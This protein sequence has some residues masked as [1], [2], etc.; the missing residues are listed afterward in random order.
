MT[1]IDH[2]NL[3]NFDLNLLLAF[4]ALMQELSVTKAAACLKVQQPAMSHSLATLRT[5]FDDELF[6]RIGNRMEPSLR[7]RALHPQ[8]R[9][10]LAESQRILLH[11]VAF[12]P[13][14]DR[15]VV[16]IGIT[17]Q[18]EP[19]LMAPLLADLSGSAPGLHILVSHTSRGEVFDAL[20]QEKIHMA[21]GYLPGGAS[22]HQRE[23]LLQTDHLCCF[24]PAQL[25]LTSPISA[26]EYTRSRHA[27]ISAKPEM[28]GY[29]EETFLALGLDLEV[30]LAAPNF[31]TLL[32]AASAAPL[33]ATLP[34]SV[35]CRYAS[36]FGLET[37]PVPFPLPVLPID[38]IWHSRS[39]EDAASCWLRKRILSCAT[40]AALQISD[41][42]P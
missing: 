10:L 7:A 4:D 20:D 22:W 39:T 33:L 42:K 3:R 35:A 6:V 5:L 31:M 29:L 30:A 40:L 34:T 28:L 19:L 23:Q 11:K 13:M 15:R 26:E 1:N 14:T 18:L 2:F 38:L 41:A 9:A 36:L 27:L 21:I 32:T 12:D 25:G 8:I 17:T 16:R 37:S 24:H